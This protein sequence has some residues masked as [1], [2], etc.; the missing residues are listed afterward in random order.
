VYVVSQPLFEVQS[1]KQMMQ[2]LV[3]VARGKHM[4]P[5]EMHF[6]QFKFAAMLKPYM[7]DCIYEYYL[8]SETE[9]TYW[10]SI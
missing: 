7:H 9:A 5:L 10:P 3:M 4:L 6:L 8:Q 2:W 1:N